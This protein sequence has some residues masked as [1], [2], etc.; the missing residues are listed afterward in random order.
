LSALVG[1]RGCVVRGGLMVFQWGDPTLSGDL[2]SASKPVLSTLL[3]AAIQEGLLSGPDDR[4]VEVEPRLASLNDGKDAEITWRHLAS[5]T[6]G[7]GLSEPPGAAYAYNDF[8]LALY[9][10]TLMGKVFKADGSEVL[11]TRLAEPLGFEDPFTYDTFPND[12][13]GRLS[14]SA[15]DFARFGLLYLYEGRWRDRQVIDRELIRMAISSPIPDNLPHTG[16][17]YADMLPGQRS[18]GGTRHITTQGPGHYSFNWWL[19]WSPATRQRL[20][21]ALPADAYLASG[22]GS[23][24]ALW[25]V[26]TWDLV[27]SWS[28]AKI[29]MVENGTD[30][31]VLRA[32]ELLREAVV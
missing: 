19:N 13:P 29:A 2:A 30:P 32:V 22:H 21:P 20:Y 5:Q 9:Y 24:K 10:E 12:R 1:G 4:L 18:L 25:I 16:R 11:R 8:A 17:V 7:Y 23:Q 27:V 14:L 31:K 6:S 3:L 15:R 28:T 26:P